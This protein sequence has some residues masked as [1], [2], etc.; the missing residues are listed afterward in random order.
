MLATR[1]GTRPEW[2]ALMAGWRWARL[3][4]DYLQNPKIRALSRDARM[5]H[6]AAILWTT[7]FTT[8]GQIPY[9]ALTDVVQDA[10]IAKKW[11]NRRA[12]EMETAGLWVPGDVG[13]ELHDY[14]DMN[15][16]AMREN[17]ERERAAWRERQARWRKYRLDNVTP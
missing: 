10:D 5:L 12:S 15:P 16:Q 2:T 3:D 9:R 13:W 7:K 1:T 8:D 4:V 11:G 6:I 14:A 17:V